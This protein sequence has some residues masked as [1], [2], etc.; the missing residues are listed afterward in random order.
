MKNRLIVHHACYNIVDDRR[1]S[2]LL[3]ACHQRYASANFWL[4]IGFILLYLRKRCGDF[5][6]HVLVSSLLTNI[7]CEKYL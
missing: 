5:G 3:H 4:C 6:R 1:F 2:L 7:F